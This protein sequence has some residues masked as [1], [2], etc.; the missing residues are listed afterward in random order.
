MTFRWYGDKAAK[1][2]RGVVVKGLTR[3][4]VEGVKLAKANASQPKGGDRHPQRQTGTLVRSITLD[5]DERKMVAKIGIMKGIAGG[6]EAL[7]YAADLEFGTNKHPPYPYL[8]PAAEAVT[9]KAKDYF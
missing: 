8:Y 9:R 1:Q 2:I 3:M 4:A 7:E 5:V 6:D